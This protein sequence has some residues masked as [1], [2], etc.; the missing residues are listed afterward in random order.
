MYNKV[1][2]NYKVEKQKVGS[3]LLLKE[4]SGIGPVKFKDTH[5][6][7]SLSLLYLLK[8][9]HVCNKDNPKFSL[10]FN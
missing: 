10:F 4:C 2:G 9:G 5:T 3:F 6:D 1:V 7:S 8:H